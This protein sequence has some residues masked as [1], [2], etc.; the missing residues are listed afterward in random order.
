MNSTTYTVTCDKESPA[1][2]KFFLSELKPREKWFT[3]FNVISIPIIVVGLILIVYRFWNGLGSVSNINQEI[4]W[5][6]WKG[7]NANNGH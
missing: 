1:G 5:S 4:P 6:L 2:W 7:F 3:P